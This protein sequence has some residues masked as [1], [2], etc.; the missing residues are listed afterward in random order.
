MGKPICAWGRFWRS[1]ARAALAA[2]RA[3]VYC[4]SR[5]CTGRRCG[6]A[7]EVGR[8]KLDSA[9]LSFLRLVSLSALSVDLRRF[10]AAP[11]P[12]CCG[13]A[14]AAA[15]VRIWSGLQ[16]A[17][18]ANA[19]AVAAAAASPMACGLGRAPSAAGGSSRAAL[20][21]AALDLP[22]PGVLPPDPLPLDPLPLDPL[23]LDPLPPLAAFR[24]AAL[25][26]RGGRG[27]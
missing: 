26:L 10:A 3:V 21:A 24:A 4:V 18:A 5:I 15:P 1:A 12:L 27:G 14:C 25:L 23:P 16:K 6:K 20:L 22:A 9:S 17:A 2:F 13:A 11:L 7:K 8:L 19:A